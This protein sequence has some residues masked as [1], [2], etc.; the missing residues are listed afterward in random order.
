[1]EIAKAKCNSIT[2]NNDTLLLC[3]ENL[4]KLL[5]DLNCSFD[6]LNKIQSEALLIEEYQDL[7]S[8]GKD[9]F[10]S[11]IESLLPNVILGSTDGKLT[12]EELNSLIAHAQRKI[13]QLHLKLEE[14]QALEI[15]HIGNA[16][17]I[18]QIED[19]KQANITLTRE[20]EKQLLDFDIAKQKLV[21]EL[22]LQHEDDLR[23]Q[24]SRQASAQFDHLRNVLKVQE[25]ELKENLE[26]IY[27]EKIKDGKNVLRE[28]MDDY[29]NQ[30]KGINEVL[31]GRSEYEVK[32]LKSQ[33]MWLS[34][35][36]VFDKFETKDQVIIKLSHDDF[37]S[38][39]KASDGNALV[40]TSLSTIPS[41]AFDIGVTSPDVLKDRF[42]KV[43]QICRRVALIDETGGSPYRYVLSYLHSL[44]IFGKSK[45]YDRSEDIPSEGLSTFI[46]MDNAAYYLDQGNVEQAAKFLNQLKGESFLMA[47]DWL[48]DARLYLET[49]QALTI[50]LTYASASGLGCFN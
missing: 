44:F 24:L 23:Q 30:L 22:N 12:E 50:L 38:I 8:K 31:D 32:A 49:K 35:Q 6:E 46:I 39:S 18:Q 47:K 4:A 40:E 29:T 20:L 3:E 11:E 7:V 42:K 27:N 25:I 34:C 16:V 21:K 48:D 2:T 15:T 43:D 13:E 26:E 10:K 14:Q 17:E 5:Y 28:K 1:M 36:K 9:Q 33:Q 41:E 37:E 19:E 45:I